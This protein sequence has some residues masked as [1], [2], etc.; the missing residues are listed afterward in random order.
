MKKRLVAILRVLSFILISAL[1]IR[2]HTIHAEWSPM[3][4]GITR[5]L[6]GIWGNSGLDIFAVGDYGTILHYDGTSWSAMSSGTTEDI[7]DVWSTSESDVF[8]VGEGE[9]EILDCRAWEFAREQGFSAQ[10]GDQVTLKGFYE[11]NDFKVG[12]V[13]NLINDQSVLLRNS[14]GKPLWS[15]GGNNGE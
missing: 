10:V 8:V 15:R 7:W 3:E 12:Q 2:V 13:D 9:K 6:K 4:S 1:M 5:D 11:N 14:D